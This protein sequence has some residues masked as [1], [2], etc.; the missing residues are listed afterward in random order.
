MGKSRG[1]LTYDE[2]NDAVSEYSSR[3]ELE[4]LMDRLHDMGI[5][6]IDNQ[7]TDITEEEIS[8][9]EEEEEE[10]EETEDIV[11]AYFHSMG[12][13]SILTRKRRN[14]ACEEIGRRKS[15]NQRNCYRTAFIQETRSEFARKSQRGF[16]PRRRRKNR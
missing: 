5:E 1:K 16:E 15:A 10:E 6:V 3:D 8:V 14:R 13:I 4:E 11:Q 9:S 7:K 12:N 2:I